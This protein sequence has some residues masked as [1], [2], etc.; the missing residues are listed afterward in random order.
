MKDI[1]I[2]GEH[3]FATSYGSFCIAPNY[4]ESLLAIHPHCVL[5]GC[6]LRSDEPYQIKVGTAAHSVSY[7]PRPDEFET[8]RALVMMAYEFGR[9]GALR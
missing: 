9:Q 3:A 5:I 6:D 8:I 7:T 1:S 2:P 4:N